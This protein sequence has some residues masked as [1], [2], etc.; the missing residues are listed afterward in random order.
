MVL[1]GTGCITLLIKRWRKL[2]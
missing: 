1:A 2:V